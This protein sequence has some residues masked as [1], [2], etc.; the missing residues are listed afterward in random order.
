[1]EK[2][3]LPIWNE[4]CEVLLHDKFRWCSY[5]L[6]AFKSFAYVE[7]MF[8]L[9]MCTIYDMVWLLSASLEFLLLKV[10]KVFEVS[11]EDKC[12]PNGGDCKT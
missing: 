3:V 1:M 6:V 4:K 2:E 10:L 11:F 12:C 5:F 8:L 7:L 9:S